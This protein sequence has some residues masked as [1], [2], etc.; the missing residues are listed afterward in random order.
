MN[1]GATLLIRNPE[2]CQEFPGVYFGL[3][4][5]QVERVVLNA[6]AKAIAACRL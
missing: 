1:V 6:L 2:A 5:A 4:K 3:L